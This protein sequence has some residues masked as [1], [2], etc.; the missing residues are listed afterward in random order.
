MTV[1]IVVSLDGW[2][3][4]AVTVLTPSASRTESGVSTRVAV[5]V[6]SSSVIVTVRPSAGATVRPPVPDVPLTRTVSSGSSMGSWRGTSSKVPV[7]LLDPAAMV[8]V[9][10]DTAEKSVPDTAVPDDTETD[11]SAS[12]GRAAAS[13]VAVTV[14]VCDASPPPP[15][16]ATASTSPS[17]TSLRRR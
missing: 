12:S 11:T 17:S 9:K 1:T 4:C 8:T 3:R 13:S 14:T 6:K 10:F 5:G 16:P 15:G 7:P 2:S